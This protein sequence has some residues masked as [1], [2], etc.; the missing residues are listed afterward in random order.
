M[1]INLSYS[2]PSR[3]V[4]YPLNL[5]IKSQGAL[6]ID[7]SRHVEPK[8]KEMMVERGIHVDH[9]TLNRWVV[10]LAPQLE[11][12]FPSRKMPSWIESAHG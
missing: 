10:R 2:P 3:V 6:A 4:D 8:A 1:Y 11:K 12:V 5:D 9:S 7:S